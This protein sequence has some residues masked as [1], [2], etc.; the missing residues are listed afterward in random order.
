[1]G[2]L[3]VQAGA[4]LK[5]FG[6]IDKSNTCFNKAARVYDL[7]LALQDGVVLCALANVLAPGSVESVHLKPGKQFL[8]MQNINAFL[9]VLPK[10]GVKDGDSFSV[11]LAYW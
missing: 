2:E 8:K 4:W 10:L 11:R 3:W 7:A 6:V 5:S 9:E 1:M